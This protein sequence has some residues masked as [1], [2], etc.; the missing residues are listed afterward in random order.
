[1]NWPAR[2]NY[3][4]QTMVRYGDLEVEKAGLARVNYVSSLQKAAADWLKRYG[5]Y[6]YFFGVAGLQNYG[7]LN[8]P[9]LPASITPGTKANGNS[10]VWMLSGG[11]PNATANEVFADIQALFY[12]LVTQTQGLLTSEDKMI[13]AMGPGPHVALN[14]TN[15]FGLTAAKILKEHFP[16]IRIVV[17][18]QYAKSSTTNPEGASASGNFIQL[19]A[20]ELGGEPTGNCAFS[21]KVRTHRLIPATSSYRQKWSSGSFGAIIKRPLAFASML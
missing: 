3:L 7:I 1:M 4:W 6:V 5:N 12:Q 21:E 11:A 9:S 2:Q 19:I 10:N 16:N 13:L 15:S 14:T 17:A 20:D 18:P 8:D